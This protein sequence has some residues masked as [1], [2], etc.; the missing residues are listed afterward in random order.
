MNRKSL[1]FEK[2]WENGFLFPIS[3]FDEKEALSCRKE[4]EDIEYKYNNSNSLPLP[5]NTYK[6][7][8]S[9]CVIPLSSKIALN[10]KI[11]DSVEKIIGKDILLWS[12]EF[13]IKEPKS[14]S[15]VS[16]HQ[17]LT[18]WGLDDH[19]LQVTAWLALSLSNKQSGCMDFVKGSF[20]N[21]IQYKL[22]D[23]HHRAF[24]LHNLYGDEYKVKCKVYNELYEDSLLINNNSKFRRKGFWVS[25]ENHALEKV[26]RIKHELKE[27]MYDKKS[28]LHSKYKLNVTVN[29]KD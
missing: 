18:Y 5:I 14:K 16:M 19:Q 26:N 21:P 24:V 10:K 20:K 29:R 4:L 9:Q 23:G 8:N 2:Y 12:V 27:G 13:F 7:V 22:L 15:M 11:L 6:R 28:K 25:K 1:D 3:I 17:D